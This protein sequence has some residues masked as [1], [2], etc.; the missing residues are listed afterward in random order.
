MTIGSG[1]QETDVV[2]GRTVGTGTNLTT[3]SVFGNTTLGGDVTTTGSQ[4]F[5]DGTVDTT[6]LT[7]DVT[8]L[9]GTNT[10]TFAGAVDGDGVAGEGRK[11][12][13]TLEPSVSGGQ[14][15]EAVYLDPVGA[16]KYV[17]RHG[18]AAGT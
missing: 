5:G 16:I 14:D 3:L 12:Y 18:V 8:T 9:A 17:Y 6:T 15:A 7:A 4:A 13:K 10:V 11:V 2:F 1:A